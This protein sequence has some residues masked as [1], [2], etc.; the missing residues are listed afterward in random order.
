MY[1]ELEKIKTIE[2]GRWSESE[3]EKHCQFS[4]SNANVDVAMAT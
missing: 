2:S 1:N 4:G 3:G